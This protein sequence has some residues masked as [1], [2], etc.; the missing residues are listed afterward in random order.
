MIILAKTEQRAR[1][2]IQTAG[3]GMAMQHPDSRTI[4]ETNPAGLHG[5]SRGEVVVVLD[6][7]SLNFDVQNRLSMLAQVGVAII[8]VEPEVHADLA[9]STTP[10]LLAELEKRGDLRGEIGNIRLNRTY[11]VD[12]RVRHWGPVPEF[13]T[14][15]EAQAWLDRE[16]EKRERA[17]E[18]PCAHT[19]GENMAGQCEEC[20]V[21][22]A[23]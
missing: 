17:A 12:I 3:L 7:A 18:P 14:A 20:G 5:L 2:Y 11:H 15:E 23:F 8:N 10:E 6:R 16:T 19:M 22:L 13:T 4:N 21:Q 1:T 9:N